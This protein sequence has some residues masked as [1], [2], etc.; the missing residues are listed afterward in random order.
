MLD[1]YGAFVDRVGNPVGGDG[2]LAGLRGA[3]KDNIAVAGSKWTCGLPL[4]VDRI[5][6][7]DAASVAVLR[8]AGAAIAGTTATD[9]AGFGMMTPG[10]INP[11]AADHTA[12]GSSGGSAAAVAGGLVDFALGTDTGG[13]V[14][15]PAACCGVFGL[16]PTFGR[17]SVEGVT[18]LST[19]FDHV[20]AIA[21]NIDILERVARVLLPAARAS[22]VDTRRIGFDPA[23]LFQCDEVI[24]AAVDRV[25]GMLEAEGFELVEVELPETLALA[26]IHGAIV[27]A[28]ALK[29]WGD[30]WPRDADRFGDTARRSLAYAATLTPDVLAGA[31]A[32][33]PVARAAIGRAFDEADA[34]IGP[35]IAVPTP[36]VGARRAVFHGHEVPVVFALLAEMCPYNVSGHP[37]LSLPLPWP[38]AGGIPVSMQIATRHERELDALGLARA[39]GRI[40]PV[41]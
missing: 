25:L 20:G 11:L 22:P 4:L 30:H 17:V 9:A 40:A 19:S 32:Q 2:P 1:P 16:K 8:A 6:Q 14:R 36:L 18:P 5:A 41:G 31:M 15:V 39:L 23:R 38:G 37:A 29:V 3:V 28:E 24:R 34:I 26:E 7:S 21:A 27:C 12:G 33:L 13:S 35:T 10:V